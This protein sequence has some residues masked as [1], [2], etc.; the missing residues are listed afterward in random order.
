MSDALKL[1]Y[2][3]T[4]EHAFDEKGR[5]TVPREWRGDGFE[6]RLYV[7]PPEPGCLK[8]YPG[9]W[10]GE[11]M[12]ALAGAAIDDPRRKSF[13]RLAAQIQGVELDRQHRITVRERLRAAAQLG[14][15]AVLTGRFDHF[16]IWSREKW[17]GDAGQLGALTVDSVLREAGL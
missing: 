16:E 1:V 7:M 8:V 5:L 6:T 10:L 3:D 2:T 14:R 12:R 11:K 15:N 17:R 4:F 9:S 13:E